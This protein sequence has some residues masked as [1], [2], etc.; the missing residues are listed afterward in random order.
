[1]ARIKY[2]PPSGV[3]NMSEYIQH[4]QKLM[5]NAHTDPKAFQ[6]ANSLMGDKAIG[7]FQRWVAKLP[8]EWNDE[9]TLADIYQNASVSETFKRVAA[10]EKG[11]TGV[12]VFATPD[13]G[14]FLKVVAVSAESLDTDED[15][16]E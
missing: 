7:A 5:S 6:E 15:D 10:G 4:V 12:G 16:A 8:Q 14:V 11:S 1:M 3:T 13:K 9:R 2:V